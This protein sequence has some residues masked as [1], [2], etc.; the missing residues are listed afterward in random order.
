LQI[1]LI[2]RNQEIPHKGAFCDL[3]W[4]DP[5]EVENWAVSPRGA[6]WLFGPKV[7]HEFL[8]TNAL[9]LICRAHQ[10]V[11]EVA[12]LTCAHWAKDNISMSSFSWF[13]LLA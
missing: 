11:H 12:L 3:V 6:G 4:S 10:L 1:R 2:E 7:T 8:T 9:Q 5:E 13:Q